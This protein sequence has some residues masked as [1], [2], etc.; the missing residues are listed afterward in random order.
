MREDGLILQTY[1]IKHETV[2]LSDR[3]VQR[4]PVNQ[5]I[6]NVEEQMHEMMGRARLCSKI[7]KKERKVGVLR[8][9]FSS[10]AL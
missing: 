5:N 6:D 7:K 3:R 9:V 10:A 1:S 4:R 8:A 2:W